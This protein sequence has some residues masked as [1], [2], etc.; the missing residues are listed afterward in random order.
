MG[1]WKPESAGLAALIVIGLAAFVPGTVR[2][3]DPIGR[4]SICGELGVSGYSMQAVNDGIARSNRRLARLQPDWE[5][6]GE[7]HLGFDFL[8]DASYDLSQT[9][10]VGVTFQSSFGKTGVDYLQ[11]IEV[12]P[13]ATMIIPRLYYRLPW[14]P[15]ID[16][17]LRA[18]GGPVFL[19]GVE[20]KIGHQNTSQG[21]RRLESMTLA[22]SGGGFIGGIMAEYTL[23]DRFTL[24]FEGG[25]RVAKAEFDS[26]NWKVENL[27]DPLDPLDLREV[28]YLWGFMNEEWEDFRHEP[29]PTI[30]E[31][32]DA[33]FSGVLA[34][35]GLRVYIF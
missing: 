33:D 6:P 23:S 35:I 16:M 27:E 1:I 31:D 15:M 32:L 24:A 8:A 9:F 14:R 25:Y 20:T 30:R 26:G 11:L 17:S 29:L 4:F 10:R 13:S 18:F 28:S 7:I 12:E 34:K 5:V 2:G 21:A 19:R 3:A 22:S